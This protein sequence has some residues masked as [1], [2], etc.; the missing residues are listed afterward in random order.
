MIGSRW[1]VVRTKPRSENLAALELSREDLEIF[2]PLI[3]G[4]QMNRG[5]SPIPLF[6]GYIFV[7]LDKGEQVWPAFRSSQHALGLL[8]FNGDVP[9][10]PDQIID[11]IKLRCESLSEIGGVWK[12]YRPGD[13]VQVINSTLHG[14]AQ[15]VEDG[16]SPN[17][18]VRILLHLFERL[19]PVQVPRHNLKPFENTPE[20]TCAPRR[21]R[22]NGRWIR[23]FGGKAHART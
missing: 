17:S 2:F 21:T 7:R 6:P 8:S 19:V 15:V 16:K 20:H 18:P 11:E 3:T 1:Y 4:D 10:L 14:I 13:W 12:T 23:G 22:G 9:W 5:S